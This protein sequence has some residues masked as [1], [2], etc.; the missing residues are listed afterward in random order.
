MQ[1]FDT[2]RPHVS[3]KSDGSVRRPDVY[4]LDKAQGMKMSK[5]KVGWGHSRRFGAS[6]ALMACC[7]FLGC[8]GTQ[9]GLPTSPNSD[10]P[11]GAQAAT[12]LPQQLSDRS[13]NGMTAVNTLSPY[14]PSIAARYEMS[15]EEL[16]ALFRDDSTLW[17]SKY[18][19]LFFADIAKEETHT[20][21]SRSHAK[22][23]AASTCI[24]PDVEVNT[25]P[26]QL[27]SKPGSSKTLFIDFES[28]VL[29]GG[30]SLWE[31]NDEEDET[32]FPPAFSTD[33]LE[34]LG[35]S[36]KDIW[37]RVATDFAPFDIDVTTERPSSDKIDRDNLSDLIFGTRVVVTAGS[38]CKDDFF[39]SGICE[40]AGLAMFNA[41][42]H[43]SGK[44]YPNRSCIQYNN[45]PTRGYDACADHEM[46]HSKFQPAWVFFDKLRGNLKDIAD[47]ISHEAGHGLGLKHFGT[48]SLTAD[49]CVKNEDLDKEYYQGHGPCLFQTTTASDGTQQTTVAIRAD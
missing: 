48:K 8:D 41:F 14:L 39:G 1:S 16:T 6:L 5:K 23:A 44:N 15:V 30:S 42:N 33:N 3:S 20:P 11:K 26:L 38:I 9:T 12:A 2:D 35:C 27:H 46:P 29:P 47:A 37:L 40:K 4:L 19:D 22:A 31:F 49:P 13:M 18:G 21:S 43:Y 10:L 25:P 36:I 45:G 34:D 32:I 28:D 7:T 17:V 24:P